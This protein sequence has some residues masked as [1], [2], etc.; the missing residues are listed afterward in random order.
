VVVDDRP[1]PVG[2]DVGDGLPGGSAYLLGLLH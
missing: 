1:E 2:F